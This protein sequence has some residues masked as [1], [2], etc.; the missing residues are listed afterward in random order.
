[1]TLL[2]WYFF[3]NDYEHMENGIVLKKNYMAN[4]YCFHEHPLRRRPKLNNLSQPLDADPV[5]YAC[6]DFRCRHSRTCL[7]WNRIFTQ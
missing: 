7:R 5:V 6:K 2:Y 1:M 4:K 3:S